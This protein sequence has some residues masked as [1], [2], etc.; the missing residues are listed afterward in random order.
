MIELQ[1]DNL[2]KVLSENENVVVQF[3]A[4]WCGGC[5]IVKPKVKKLSESRDDITFVYVDAESLPN[6]RKLANVSNLPTLK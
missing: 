2:E 4:T 3:G 1:E 5:R 6:S